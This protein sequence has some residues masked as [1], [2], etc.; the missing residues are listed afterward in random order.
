MGIPAEI[1]ALQK[2]R[3]AHL[4][5]KDA[6]F[7]LPGEL[8]APTNYRITKLAT[9]IV[10]K[11][12]DGSEEKREI[13]SAGLYIAGIAKDINTGHEKW[14]VVMLRGDDQNSMD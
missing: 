5:Q 2:E 6:T 4:Q 8:E 9:F 11:K 10:S 13:A 1:E 14:F 3:E 12:D 7:T